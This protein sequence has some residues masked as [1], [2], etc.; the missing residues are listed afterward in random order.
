[1]DERALAEEVLEAVGHAGRNGQAGRL[2]LATHKKA[3]D[4]RPALK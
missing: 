2:P 4:L 3:P 1:L